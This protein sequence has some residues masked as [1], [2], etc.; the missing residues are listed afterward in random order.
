MRKRDFTPLGLVTLVAGVVLFCGWAGLAAPPSPTKEIAV[1]RTVLKPGFLIQKAQFPPNDAK[2]TC[3]VTAPTFAS[4]FQSGAPALNGVVKPADSVAFPNAPNCSFYQWSEQMFLWLTSPAPSQYGGGA[5]IFDS[6][7]FYDVSAPDANNQRVFIPHKNGVIR[8]FNLRAAQPGPHNLPVI[9]DRAGRMFEIETQKP[10]VK[11]LVRNKAGSLVE[12]QRV[13]AGANGKRALLDKAGKEVEA[14]VSPKAIVRSP[15]PLLARK[16]ILNNIPVLL[17]ANGN[18][19]DTEPGQAGGNGV[20]QAQNGSLVYYATMVN[21]VYAYFLTGAKDG[22][23]TPAPTQFPT[24]QADLNK[25]VAFAAMHS[26]TFPD[27][28]ALAIEVKTSWV[29]AAGLPNLSGYITMTATIPTYSKSNQDQWTPSGQKNA[30]LALVGVHVVGSTKGHPE[31]I[32][33]TF[34]H[35]GNAP[36]GTYAYINSSNVTKTVNQSTAGTWLFTASG[37]GGPFNA[38][39]MHYNTVTPPPPPIGIIANAPF[40]ISPS[41]TILWKA[42]GGAFNVSPNPLDANTAA[43]NTEIIAIN[44]SVMGQLVGGD[45]RGNYIMTG[46]TWTIGGAAPSGSFNAGAGNEVG[47]SK[48]ANATMETYQQGTDNLWASGTNCF[49]CHGTNQTT[50]SH[51]YPPLKPLF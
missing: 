50:V 39:H 25:I 6:P 1:K 48:L 16:F 8:P 18:V 12:I 11:P 40:H 2:P 32:W 42:W 10:E 23:I 47:T 31:M 30:L 33:A 22:G 20:L 29:E 24:T 4:W 26:K 28:N 49:S 27:P 44:N 7:T 5:H 35:F 3:T 14:A 45:I 9:F 37:S 19:L 43:S 21:D 51:I 41:D 15:A 36:A 17:D 13:V 38:L 34:E 46:S